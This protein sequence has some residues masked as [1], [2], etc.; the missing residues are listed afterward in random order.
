MKKK[1]LSLVL[2]GAMVTSTSV[3]AF[4]DTN[5]NINQSDNT[6]PKADVE[7]TGKVLSEGGEEAPGVF[8]VTIPTTAAFTVDGSANVTSATI[9][10]TNGGSQGIDVY[11]EKFVDTTPNTDDQI[12]VVEESQLNN[13]NRT[14]VSL[15][16]TGHLRSL[17]LKSED[18]TDGQKN[19]L[20]TDKALTSK[21]TDEELKLISIASGHEGSLTLGGK[22]GGANDPQPEAVNNKFTLTLKIKKSAN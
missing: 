9:K 21:A 2:A 15:S 5:T 17:H 6:T 10:I 22:A 3:S 20:Y 18:T 7:I 8:N 14:N 16:I 1:L 4:A 19:G 11:A 13:K 12:T